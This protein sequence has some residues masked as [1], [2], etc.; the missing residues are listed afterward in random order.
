MREKG[1]EELFCAVRRLW[2]EG[3]HVHLQLLGFFEEQYRQEVDRLVAGG[4]TEFFG[5]QKE[6]LPFYQNCDCVVL[7]SYHEG[8]SNVLLEAAAVGRPIIASDIP[9]CREAVEHSKTGLL[10]RAKDTDSLYVA[11]RAFLALSA[12]QKAALG[13]NG[14][15]KMEREFDKASVVAETLRIVT[16]EKA[17]PQPRRVT[18]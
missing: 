9:G 2:T 15:R 10:C 12:E 4:M 14:R 8:M 11:M 17:A 13:Q 18:A 16:A 3:F 5:F 7:P 1:V 6:P